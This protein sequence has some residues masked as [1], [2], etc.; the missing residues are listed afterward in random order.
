MWGESMF[1]VYRFLNKNFE[2]IYVGRTVN[3]KKR[4]SQ[5]F[6]KG[7]LPSEC[8]K[9]VARIDYL[10]L[11]TKADMNIVELYFIGKYRPEFN[12]RDNH[13]DTSLELNEDKYAW[14]K[15]ETEK[16][17]RW[18]E[19]SLAKSEVTWAREV[20][21]E[22]EQHVRDL[23]FK[24]L[25]KD[26]ELADSKESLKMAKETIVNLSKK[27]I[28]QEQKTCQAERELLAAYNAISKAA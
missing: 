8:Y 16:S 21:T 4:M 7:H 17:R 10:E 25:R 19:D 3:I 2:V 14:V 11:E 18:V 12:V 13:S 20:I 6:T 28:D 24:L 5:H 1:Y 26:I 15:Y 9:Q 22:L 23:E 27:V